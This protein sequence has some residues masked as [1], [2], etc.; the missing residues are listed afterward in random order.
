MNFTKLPGYMLVTSIGVSVWYYESYIVRVLD[1]ENR[2]LFES[3]LP[4]LYIPCHGVSRKA[5]PRL[6]HPTA[7]HLSQKEAFDN[8]FDIRNR[9]ACQSENHNLAA[10]RRQAIVKASVEAIGATPLK[11]KKASGPVWCHFCLSLLAL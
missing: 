8:I 1:R 10:S 4:I 9:L 5:Q 3:G 11:L 6:V 2:K 7:E